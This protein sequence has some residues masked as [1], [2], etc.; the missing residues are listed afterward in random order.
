M[1]T[2]IAAPGL[3]VPREDNPRQYI[4]SKPTDVPST[5]YYRRRL[6]SGELQAAGRPSTTTTEPAPVDAVSTAPKPA[7]TKTKGTKE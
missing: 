4:E 7:A 6:A 2:V 1:P 5:A 3:R